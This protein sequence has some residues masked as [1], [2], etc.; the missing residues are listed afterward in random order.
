[1][2]I[3][4]S[5]NEQP[6]SNLQRLPLPLPPARLV[7][8]L[9]PD[10]ILRPSHA[11]RTALVQQR[12]IRVP[13][14]EHERAPGPRLDR[15]G[16]QGRLDGRGQ[17]EGRAAAVKV[18]VEVDLRN[19]ASVGGRRLRARGER[20]RKVRRDHCGLSLGLES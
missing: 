13:V 20:T 5:Q 19:E 7:Q 8:H 18:V 6:R 4:D 14:R 1:M 10:H 15:V 12:V 16:V 3:R 2:H 9:R 17:E 11:H